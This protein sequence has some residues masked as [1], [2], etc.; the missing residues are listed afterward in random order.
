M[1]T[2][3]Q[4]TQ[5]Y[6]V[7]VQNVTVSLSLIFSSGRLCSNSGECPKILSEV[8]GGDVFFD[9]ASEITCAAL[10]TVKV[11]NWENNVSVG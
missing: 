2:E 1:N 3:G 6:G 9:G 10:P 8:F 7:M 4:G 11:I 5:I